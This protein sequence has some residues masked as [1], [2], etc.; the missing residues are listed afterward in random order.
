VEHGRF[1][2]RESGALPTTASVA[3]GAPTRAL[4]GTD[5]G[6][7]QV[8][9][10]GEAEVRRAGTA[11]LVGVRADR[12]PGETQVTV[13]PRVSVSTRRGAWTGRLGG[14]VFHQGR[15]QATPAIPDAG[16]PAGTP[17]EARHLVAG[18]EHEGA[19]TLRAE[20]F[21]KRYGDY[22]AQGDGP[23]IASARARGMDVSAQRAMGARTTGWVSYSLLDAAV[24][25]ADGR[26]ARSPYDVTHSLTT[27]ATVTLGADWSL[28]ATARYG[29]GAPITPVLGATRSADGRHT[30][31][32][33]APTSERLPAYGRLDARLTRFIR[34]P[35][36]LLTS[37]VEAINVTDR[38][39]ASA[40]TYDAAYR[41]RQPVHSFFASRTIVVGGELQLR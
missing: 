34:A 27:S 9:G 38:A 4:D 5:A 3:P 12:L 20:A 41:T 28:G 36:F 26:Q 21:D 15:W 7:L 19:T 23:P 1:S 35:R 6:T 29:T 25:L 40:V 39:N 2:R 18:I 17:R 16:T 32:Y 14:G 8:G 22:V 13:D 37:F 30:P 33:G 11:L 31:V 24:R 10:Y